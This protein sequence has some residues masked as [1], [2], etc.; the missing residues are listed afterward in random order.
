MVANCY[1]MRNS[2]TSLYVTGLRKIHPSESSK[3][4]PTPYESRRLMTKFFTADWHLGHVN[5][6]KFSNRPWK[7]IDDMNLS[8]ISSHNSLV[9]VNDQVYFLGDFAMKFQYV[10]KYLPY[11]NGQWFWI[12][13]NHDKIWWRKLAKN[14]NL[15]KKIVS[16][17]EILDM[18]IQKQPVTLCHYPM[19]SW[20]RSH[21]NSWHLFGH[22]H[23]RFNN[24]KS[25]SM[26]VGL[27]ANNYTILSEHDIVRAMQERAASLQTQLAKR[28]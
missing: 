19:V 4:T 1:F 23:G 18:Y 20:N 25:L 17:H 14:A 13:G 5:I 28:G 10:E 7:N 22:V 9:G 11:L 6:L 12:L 21:Y 8:I 16:M 24:P 2:A 3:R 26:D 15:T 27:D